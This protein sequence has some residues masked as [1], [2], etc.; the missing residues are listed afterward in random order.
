MESDHNK[1]INIG[2]DRLVTINELADIITKIRQKNN[3]K[4]QPKRAARSTRQKRRPYTGQ[5]SA[6]L[7]TA[8]H[9]RTRP[10]KNIQMDR[11][12]SKRR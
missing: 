10:N 8:S 3:E 6:K 11:K 1:P 7:A 2:F 5:K 9:A 12:E 4:I